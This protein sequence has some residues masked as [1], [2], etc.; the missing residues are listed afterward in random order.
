MSPLAGVFPTRYAAAGAAVAVIIIILASYLVA[1]TPGDVLGGYAA[2]SSAEAPAGEPAQYTLEEG[3]TA[4]QVGDDLE[5]L[6]VVTSG[7]QFELLVGLM[8]V[9]GLISAGDY[10]LPRGA[11][12]LSIVDRLT[13]KE[14]VPVLKVTF[15]EGIRMEEMALLA[16]DA[17]FGTREEFAAAVGRARL[18]EGLA[19]TLPPGAS[20]QGYLFPDTYVL[21]EGATMDDLVGLMITTL[22]E[23]FTPELRAAA[24]EQGLNPHEALTLAAIVEREAVLPEERPLIAGV[25]YNRLKAGDMLGADPTVQFVVAQDPKSVAEFGWWKKELTQ[26]ELDDPD[27][28]NTRAVPGLPPGPITNPG[29]ASIEA[30]AHPADTEYYYFVANAVKADGSHV[31]AV[32]FDDHQRN[33]AQFGAP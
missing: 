8:G 32:T 28:Y 4:G 17:G 20:L 7:R 33:D 25:F 14:A 31:F 12:P 30:V 21:P 16:E 18:P 10:I 9:E 23:R 2:P 26:A 15:P 5:A 1:R 6:G 19:A 11:A 27:P 24:L 13:V 29:L 22:D 3:R